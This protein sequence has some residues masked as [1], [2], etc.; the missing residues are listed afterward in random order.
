[1]LEKE[2]EQRFDINQVDE[3][4]KTTPITSVENLEELPSK[5]N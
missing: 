2:S 4:I 1:M 5:S 3:V